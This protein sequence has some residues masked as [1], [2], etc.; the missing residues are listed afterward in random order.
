MVNKAMV[1]KATDNK[2]MVIKVTPNKATTVS[3]ATVNRT[4]MV[5]CRNALKTI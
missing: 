5:T 2:D 4:I 1:S 3:K